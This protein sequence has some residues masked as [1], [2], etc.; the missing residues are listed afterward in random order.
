L[1]FRLIR[2]ARFALAAV[3]SC[4]PFKEDARAAS[5][6]G[7]PQGDAAMS[8]D[9]AEIAPDSA[10]DAGPPCRLD[11]PFGPPTLVA[12]LEAIATAVLGLRL[13]ADALTAYF[14]DKSTL[15]MATRPSPTSPFDQASP[16]PIGALSD[17]VSESD[18]TV[19]GDGLTLVFAAAASSLQTQLYYATR[20]MPSA[21]FDYLGLTPNVNDLSAVDQQPFLRADGQVLY[22]ASS[23][24]PA[25]LA[26]IYRAAWNG[27]SFAA[28]MPVA[29]LN[30]AFN[31]YAP[32]VTG[33]DTILYFASGRSGPNAVGGDDIWKAT[34]PP[35]GGAFSTPTNVTE[36]NSADAD[37]PT[38]VTADGCAI[39]FSSTRGRS[40]PQAYVAM[41]PPQ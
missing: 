41:K 38:F 23:R 19:S 14:A 36:L 22:F 10:A 26:D 21:P 13:S 3:A 25:D 29:E 24:V 28:P 4:T 20:T 35:G 39:Y 37:L 1:P 27:S 18:P 8:Y 9:D 30:T 33:D 32:V 6:D 12:G 34:R 40:V 16:L 2:P 11:Q 5:A 7:A 17:P 31:D 15:Y